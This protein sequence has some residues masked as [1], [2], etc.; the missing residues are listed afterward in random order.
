MTA[1]PSPDLAALAL[2]QGFGRLIRDREDFGVVMLCDPRIAKR[3][4]GRLFVAS[5][6]PAPVILDESEATGFLR[7]QLARAGLTLPQ[8]AG[9]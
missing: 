2:K 3:G 1:T 7:R 9:A 8:A 4:Y 6:P 5:L